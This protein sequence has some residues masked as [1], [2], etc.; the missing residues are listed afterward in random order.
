MSVGA[1]GTRIMAV[2]IAKS[3]G[4]LHKNDSLYLM[5]ARARFQFDEINYSLTSAST[6]QVGFGL[7]VSPYTSAVPRD[8]SKNV[9]I[10]G[11]VVYN[12]KSY[13]VTRISNHAFLGC[14]LIQEIS[15]PST[16]TTLQISCFN[17]M[18]SLVSLIFDGMNQIRSLGADILAYTKLKEL[19]IPSSVTRLHTKI[20]RYTNSNNVKVS[21]CGLRKFE[22]FE[23]TRAPS[24]VYVSR[25]YPYESFGNIP[26]SKSLYCDHQ[27][28]K[29]CIIKRKDASIKFRLMF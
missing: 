22:D 28:C 18:T 13:K 3:R 29:S 23:L 11:F 15:I 16:V 4:Y 2:H 7:S 5:S 10:P 25:N 12:G 1:R 6:A 14:G 8:Y 26:V 20:F 19:V 27:Q 24:I 21:Y 17:S 9:S